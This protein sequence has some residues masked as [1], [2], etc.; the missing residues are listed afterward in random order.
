MAVSFFAVR[1]SVWTIRLPTSLQE[2]SSG[3]RRCTNILDDNLVYG[4]TIAEH[5]ERLRRVLDRLVKYNAT[6]RRDKCVIGVTEVD[7]NGHHISASGIQPLQSNVEAIQKIYV[8][9]DQ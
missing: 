7:F 2:N 1:S 6:V 3:S 5:D 4:R 8:P 9:V